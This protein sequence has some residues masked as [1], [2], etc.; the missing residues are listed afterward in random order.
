MKAWVIRHKPTGHLM[1]CRM[2]RNG[3]GGWSWWEPTLY[4]DPAHEPF[5]THPRIFWTKLSVVNALTQWLRGPVRRETV[6]SGS[7]ESPEEYCDL[8]PQAPVVARYRTDVEIV[9]V[10]VTVP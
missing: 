2:S 9:E 8:V 4:A 3:F 7:W 10:E 5:D 1:P 6:S